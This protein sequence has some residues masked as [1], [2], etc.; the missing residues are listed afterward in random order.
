MC[1]SDLMYQERGDAPSYQAVRDHFDA[2][3]AIVTES[4]GAVLKTI[5]DSVMVVFRDPYHAV[6]AALAIQEASGRWSSGLVVKM[7]LHQGPALAVNAND[8]LDYFGQT[9]NLAARLLWESEGRD[10][11]VTRALLEDRQVEKLLQER[12]CSVEYFTQTVRGLETPIAMARIGL[13]NR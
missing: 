13:P 12:D 8:L 1:S 2:I 10:L 9:V 7:G 11:V 5:G 6:S 3:R 4:Y